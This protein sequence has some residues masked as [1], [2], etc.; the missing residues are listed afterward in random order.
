MGAWRSDKMQDTRAWRST[1]SLHFFGLLFCYEEGDN[2]NVVTFFFIFDKKKNDDSNVIAFFSMF[3]KKKMM[4]M[5]HCLFLWWCV[6]TNKVLPFLCFSLCLKR[7]RWRQWSSSSSLVWFHK[8]GEGSY[9]Y[10]CLFFFFCD[11]NYCRLLRWFCCTKDD[12]SKLSPF[13]LYLKRKQHCYHCLL[14]WIFF[15]LKKWRRQQWPSSSSF[16][17]LQTKQQ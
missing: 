9:D 17:L 2:S 12:G 5:C 14:L 7:R 13:F 3:E 4:T 10:H 15:Y 16:M 8:E 1:L 6:V 11:I